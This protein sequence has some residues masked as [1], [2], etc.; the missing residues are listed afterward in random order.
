MFDILHCREKGG[1]AWIA[2][3]KYGQQSCLLDMRRDFPNSEL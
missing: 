2:F 3:K 1:K